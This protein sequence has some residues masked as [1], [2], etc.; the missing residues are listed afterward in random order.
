VSANLDLQE[1][2]LQLAKQIANIV[3]HH[4]TSLANVNMVRPYL[5]KK[6]CVIDYWFYF[7]FSDTYVSTQVLPTPGIYSDPPAV[8]PVEPINYS[9]SG[10]SSS[11]PLQSEWLATSCPQHVVSP[12]SNFNNS[13]GFRTEQCQPQQQDYSSYYWN[14]WDYSPPFYP[15]SMTNP[16]FYSNTVFDPHSSSYCFYSPETTNQFYDQSCM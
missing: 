8:P 1:R 7:I 10:S 13:N 14:N 3:D 5:M 4:L 16:T 9:T 15:T 6:I 12:Q 11:S 2:Q